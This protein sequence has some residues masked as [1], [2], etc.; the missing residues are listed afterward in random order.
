MVLSGH[1]PCYLPSLQFFAK[2]KKSDFFLHCGHL[3]FEHGSWHNRNYI[4]LNGK[5]HRLTIPAQRPHL[6]PIRDIRFSDSGLQKWK[7]KH[8]KTITLAYGKTPFFNAYYPELKDIIHSHPNSLERLNIEL[9]N[10]I[11]DW[12]GITT[13]MV[14]GGKFNFRG[15]AVDMIIQMCHEVGADAYLSNTG[16]KAYIFDAEERRMKEAGVQSKWL[17]FID[18]CPEGAE[19]LSVVHHLFHLGPE[20]ARLIE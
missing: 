10:K 11:A 16:S 12:L 9:T 7:E 6:A 13:P 14:D 19:P 18:P 20:A 17:D 8:L 3:Q 2:I 15:D 5:R 4:L 1:Q